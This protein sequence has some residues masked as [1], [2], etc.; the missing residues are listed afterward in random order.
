MSDQVVNP[1]EGG[2]HQ[3]EGREE[4]EQR[5]HGL[6]DAQ[7][8]FPHEMLCTTHAQ[9]PEASCVHKAWSEALSVP[10]SRCPGL[11]PSLSARECWTQL[12]PSLV[13]CP[14]ERQ[15][16]AEAA[17]HQGGLPRNKAK[18]PSHCH[19]AELL[20]GCLWVTHV[21]KLKLLLLFRWIGGCGLSPEVSLKNKSR[22]L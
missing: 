1:S 13:P 18:F 20:T 4:R 2:G 9:R 16:E 10:W 12:I 11:G 7:G 22:L 3:R 6:D 14:T 15:V 8:S 21:P 19:R 5:S 17:E